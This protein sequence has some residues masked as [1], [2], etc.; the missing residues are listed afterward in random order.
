MKDA[1][2]MIWGV[3]ALLLLCAVIWVVAGWGGMRAD[4]VS[5]DHPPTQQEIHDA[6]C[7]QPQ[8]DN[9]PSC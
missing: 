3:A 4:Q 5:G 9:D 7:A 1:T 8:Y 2:D 6:V